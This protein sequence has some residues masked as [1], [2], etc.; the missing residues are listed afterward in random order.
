MRT[1]VIFEG[2]RH[3]CSPASKTTHDNV[4]VHAELWTEAAEK[5]AQEPASAE[6]AIEESMAPCCRGIATQLPGPPNLFANAWFETSS[7]S[8]SLD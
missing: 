2:G 4:A 6:Q 3:P 7:P 1:P 8:R 5:Q